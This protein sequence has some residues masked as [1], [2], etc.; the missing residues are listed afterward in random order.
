MHDD[1][2]A[3]K[4]ETNLKTQESNM[5]GM[6]GKLRRSYPEIFTE[7]MYRTSSVREFTSMRSMKDMD[8]TTTWSF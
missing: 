6:H 4:V 5:H 3:H 8:S 1:F 7:E 2:H